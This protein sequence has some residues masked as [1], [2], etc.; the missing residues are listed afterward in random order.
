VIEVATD[1]SVH[2]LKATPSWEWP[3]EAGNR[4]LATLLDAD[5]SMT[6]EEILGD[7]LESY[8]EDIAGA[9][10]EA[11]VMARGLSGDITRDDDDD[12]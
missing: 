5:A 8:D 4:L 11:L 10:E 7:L 1:M 6:A 12:G 3:A 2:D 9:V